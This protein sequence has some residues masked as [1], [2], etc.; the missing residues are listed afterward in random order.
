MLHAMHLSNVMQQ[1][2]WGQMPPKFF[3]CILKLLSIQNQVILSPIIIFKF[4]I[5]LIEWNHFNYKMPTCAQTL[6]FK[7]QVPTYKKV[8]RAKLS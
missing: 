8:A 3:T 4:T 5:L 6:E 2:K 7:V 1:K